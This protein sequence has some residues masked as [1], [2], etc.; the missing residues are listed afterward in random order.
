MH[1]DQTDLY[2]EILK[3]AQKE[4]DHKLVQIIVEKLGRTCRSFPRRTIDGCQIFSFPDLNAPCA[5]A[6]SDTLHW[7]STRF[8]RILFLMMVTYGFFTTWFL[9]FCQHFL[10]LKMW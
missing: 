4:S 3:K 5:T 7:K 9:F 6:E 10:P 2:L 1:K 8:W